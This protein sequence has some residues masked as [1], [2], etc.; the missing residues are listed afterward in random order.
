MENKE[1]F[2]FIFYRTSPWSHQFQSDDQRTD[3]VEW[4]EASR[5]RRNVDPELPQFKI[6]SNQHVNFVEMAGG[7]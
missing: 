2:Q 5:E 6:L 4:A 1:D 7:F 3:D